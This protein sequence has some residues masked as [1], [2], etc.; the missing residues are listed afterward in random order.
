MRLVVHVLNYILDHMLDYVLDHMLN[1]I[2]DCMIICFMTMAF[3]LP[4]SL[5]WP[6]T[7]K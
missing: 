3:K 7:N 5:A 4:S 1:H 2:I 6:S